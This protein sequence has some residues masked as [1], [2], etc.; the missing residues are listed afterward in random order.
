MT[1]RTVYLLFSEFQYPNLL[2]LSP[3][4]PAE[5]LPCSRHVE[6]DASCPSSICCLFFLASR[7]PPLFKQAMCPDQIKRMLYPHLPCEQ[8]WPSDT[9][10]VS[11]SEPDIFI[12]RLFSR[13]MY[14]PSQLPLLSVAILILS[15]WNTDVRP[16]DEVAIL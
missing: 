8:G 11:K 13:Y 7:T 9:V 15:A 14:S 10:L 4:P 6:Y 5:V 12:K 3:L 2:L 1:T 16:G